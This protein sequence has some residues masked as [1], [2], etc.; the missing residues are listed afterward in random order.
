MAELRG[1]DVVVVAGGLGLAP[2]RPAV[3]ALLVN[4][5]EFGRL[6][7]LY[8]AR[9]PADLL[10]KREVEQWRG[11]FDVEVMVSVDAATPS[12]RGEV[13]V[14]TK[15]FNRVKVDSGRAAALVCGPE[16]MMRFAAAALAD[17]GFE[18]SNV[19]L[20]MER[21]MQCGA[22]VCGHCQIGP[23]LV[24]RDGPVLSMDRLAP[25]LRIKEL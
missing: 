20:S 4:R 14:V 15:L 1:K 9:T 8:G 21:N 5:A 22:G 12:W 25:L 2:L 6:V 13:G 11:R 16:I 17:A 18:D 19:W 24:C 7:L 23:L 3:H 10:F